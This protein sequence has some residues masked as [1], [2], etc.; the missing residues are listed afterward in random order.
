MQSSALM[1]AYLWSTNDGNASWTINGSQDS[2]KV[3]NQRVAK[4]RTVLIPIP[5][6]L[7]HGCKYCSINN[8][9]NYSAYSRACA[10][11]LKKESTGGQISS[12]NNRKR[13][14]TSVFVSSPQP[15]PHTNDWIISFYIALFKSRNYVNDICV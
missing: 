2:A 12:K 7:S 3:L 11:G 9:N 8:T 6:Q 15:L 1:K 5:R 4:S 13:P 10:F 14:R